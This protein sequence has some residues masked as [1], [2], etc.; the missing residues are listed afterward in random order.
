[1]A[2]D[3]FTISEL[4]VITAAEVSDK[5]LVKIGVDDLQ[6]ATP[7]SKGMTLAQ[8][9]TCI[10]TTGG[11]AGSGWPE[12]DDLADLR[13]ATSGTLTTTR[14]FVRGSLVA[15][16]G[17]GGLFFLL[18]DD[19]VYDSTYDDGGMHIV[20]ASGR[21]WA[22]EYT[23]ILPIHWGIDI[24]A[25]ET[26]AESMADQYTNLQKFF[27]YWA[28]PQ[29]T[30]RTANRNKSLAWAFRTL[31]DRWG[32]PAYFPPGYARTD[33]TISV[34]GW[35]SSV[36]DGPLATPNP[37]QMVM[38]GAVFVKYSVNIT[39][40][41]IAFQF[42]FLRAAANFLACKGQTDVGGVLKSAWDQRVHTQTTAQCKYPEI[43]WDKLTSFIPWSASLQLYENDKVTHEHASG[44]RYLYRATAKHTTGGSAPTHTTGTTANL[45]C[46]GEYVTPTVSGGGQFDISDIASAEL[47]VG[48]RVRAVGHSRDIHFHVEAQNFAIQ[49]S[50]KPDM[51]DARTKNSLYGDIYIGQGFGCKIQFAQIMTPDV[52]NANGWMNAM[53]YHL[54]GFLPIANG[55]LPD[56]GTDKSI[57][58]VLTILDPTSAG[59]YQSN[60]N[61]FENISVETAA[62]TGNA[63]IV[64]I[65]CLYG[66]ENEFIARNDFA[67]YTAV[68][69][70]NREKMNRR[71]A[72]NIVK[73]LRMGKIDDNGCGNS[74]EIYPRTTEHYA[75]QTMSL[76]E[77]EIQ[78][79]NGVAG[80]G[81]I[82][83]PC[84]VLWSTG[85]V[86]RAVTMAGARYK[87]SVD[88]WDFTDVSQLPAF[89]LDFGVT[90]LS[91]GD[92][93]GYEWCNIDIEV[94]GNDPLGRVRFMLLDHET[95]ANIDPQRYPSFDQGGGLKDPN[96][97]VPHDIGNAYCTTSSIN[98]SADGRGKQTW[99]VAPWVRRIGVGFFY[100]GMSGATIKVRGNRPVRFLRY[101]TKA[102]VA[103]PPEHGIWEGGAQ[104]DV[105]NPFGESA[106]R[107]TW[108][109]NLD[110]GS[111]K[112]LRREYYA[113]TGIW[114][115]STSYTA[116]Q[117]VYW[118]PSGIN[119]DIYRALSTFTSSGT[120]PTDDGGG[121]RW[122]LEKSAVPFC[123]PSN[124][125]KVS[126]AVGKMLRY[127]P[128]SQMTART[129]NGAASGTVELGTNKNMLRTLDFD[130]TTAEFAQF[131]I[132]MPKGWNEGTVT[133]EP[134][135]SHP[136]TA[137]NF[138]VTW[139][140]QA[141][142]I[143]N[144]DARD[145]AF[146][147]AQ[148][149][150]DTGGTT[151]DFYRG[152]ESAAITIA[153]SPAEGDLVQFQISR[154]PTDGG[155][156]LAV[157]ARLSGIRLYF[158]TNQAHEG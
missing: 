120:S 82:F 62:R 83:P 76:R 91:G 94:F 47:D 15:N 53:R 152:P 113:V 154:D 14:C 106:N 56:F 137:T 98:Y 96:G 52:T 142:A 58:G 139:K 157:D 90:P 71:P 131:E 10:D 129:T 70:G 144:D 95:G 108:L 133:F 18:K 126:G 45:Q 151:D 124:W 42:H 32:R 40:I 75:T 92:S 6:S 115:N 61:L 150:V 109:L 119:A 118:N 29:A 101:G 60:G 50:H 16:D 67:T 31:E 87:P 19:I 55:A 5:T 121:G 140:L 37:G 17:G 128:A 43:A 35:I 27:D 136:A 148:S 36:V 34:E 146:G 46:L 85:A 3:Q 65:C 125:I 153:G 149:S 105:R 21:I 132:S 8:L 88:Q 102:G 138:G 11:G 26:A 145:V 69:F 20:D 77:S 112:A 9:Q 81:L 25:T 30:G 57:Y 155:D 33:T 122:T 123:V 134:E 44:A 63:E 24:A 97:L 114:T 39:A 64:Q 51:S 158:T 84:P 28:D 127:I 54:A 59:D 73:V 100:Q 89:I 104:L 22:R 72:K 141:V 48:I 78:G 130:S 74:I 135:W 79:Y 7:V 103:N 111:D 1:M 49:V 110:V 117:L 13:A 116:N 86:K 12:F 38:Q 66:A 4:P 41:N 156:T 147:T 107:L 68:R 23:V 99:G 93:R 2:G 80:D 143:S